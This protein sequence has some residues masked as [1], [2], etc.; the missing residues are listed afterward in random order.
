[1]ELPPPHGQFS[2][3][4]MLLYPVFA[5]FGGLLGYVLR[6]MDAG[7]AVSVWRAVVEALSA[8]F[9]GVLVMLICEATHLNA[10][11]T[12]VMVGVCGWLGATA[13]IRMLERIVRGKLGATASGGTTDDKP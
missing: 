9:V 2:V 7:A 5:A 13:S 4:Q 3:W 12:G 1:M 6:A 8:G 10:Q 11:W